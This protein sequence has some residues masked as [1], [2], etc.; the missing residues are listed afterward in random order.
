MAS[1]TIAFAYNN[2][3]NKLNIPNNERKM[4]KINEREGNKK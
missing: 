1:D 2:N 4:K 3:N